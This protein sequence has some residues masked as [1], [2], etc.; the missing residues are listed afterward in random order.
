M[1]LLLLCDVASRCAFLHKFLCCSEAT[2]A[3][4]VTVLNYFLLSVN[5]SLAI[6]LE[7]CDKSMF[8]PHP[9]LN[10][11]S[12]QPFK[13]SQS[14]LQ[15]NEKFLLFLASESTFSLPVTLLFVAIFIR[16]CRYSCVSLGITM[17]LQRAFSAPWVSV[18]MKIVFLTYF[19][20]QIFAD[21][22]K[23]F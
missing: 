12:Y 3:S 1:H 11:I 2:V 4:L 19:L 21:K 23:N 8:L 17:C 7:D 20:H 9:L 10:V 15:S 5:T 22:D 16:F 18:H 14:W 13:W 6:L